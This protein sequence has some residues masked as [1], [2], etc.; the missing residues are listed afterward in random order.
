MGEKLIIKKIGFS[1]LLLDEIE[2]FAAKKE[3]NF[4]DAVRIL[5]QNALGF[6]PDEWIKDK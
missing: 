6:I 3:L 5:V 1:I 4:S 2:A